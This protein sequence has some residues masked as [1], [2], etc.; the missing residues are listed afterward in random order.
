MTMKRF[1]LIVAALLAAT[2]V[3]AQVFEWKDESGKTHYSDMPP[4]GNVRELRKIESAP[5]ATGNPTQK[6]AADREMEFR[7]NL[8]ESQEKTEKTS[9][10]QAA[11]SER[12]E[13]CDNARRQQQLLESGERIALRDDKGERYYMDDAQREQEIAKARQAVQSF[14]K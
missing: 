4:P 5:P 10:Q 2:A 9:K 11:A 3:H 13:N 8:K 14:C 7:K 12:N 1:A 6:T